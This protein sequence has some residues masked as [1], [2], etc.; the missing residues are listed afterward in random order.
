MKYKL[1]NKDIK[2][3]YLEELLRERGVTDIEQFLN[4]DSSCLQSFNDL[5]NIKKGIEFLYANLCEDKP[6]ALIVDCDIDGFTSASII[7]LYLKKVYPTLEIDYYIHSG[8]QH[9]L[10]DTWQKIVDSGRDYSLIIIPDAGSN[11]S[12]Y[13]EKLDVPILVLDHHLV[14]DEITA[15]KMVVVNNQLSPEYR[16]KDLSGAGVAY[17]FCRALDAESGNNY[18]EE[19]IDLAAVGIIGDMMSSLEPENQYIWKTG[20]KSINNTFLK[21][22]IDKQSYS[23][24]GKI[25]PISVAFYIVPL[26]NAMIRVGTIDEKERMFIAFI[27]GDRLIPCNKRGAKGTMERAAIE[28]VRECVNAKS[29]QTRLLDSAE[30][31]IEIKIFKY[32]L[33]ENKI[34]IVRLEEDDD[35][36]AELNGLVAMRLAAKHKRPTIVARLNDQGYV[37]GSIRGV[38]NGPIESFKNFLMDSGYCEYVM[39]HDNAAGVSFKNADLSK[40]HAYAN[41]ALSNVKLDEDCFDVNFVRAAADKDI[42]EIIKIVADYGDIWGQKND[43]PKFYIHDINLK[44]SDLQVIGSKKDTLKF[45]KF[46]IVYIKFHATDFIEELNQYN[47]IK[48]EVVGR[49]NVNEWMGTKTPQIMIEGYEIHDDTLGF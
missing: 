44:K 49:G 13:A 12:E 3:N 8:K 48:L 23:M 6:M 9:G 15:P 40:L 19:F 38:N 25:N 30:E 37:R 26:V 20:L 18:A 1:V 2:G 47:D 33:L 10:Q 16:N 11:D 7:Y 43:E 27:D 17:Q 22:L 31:Q 28:S 14:E 42:G 41:E 5:K 34:L 24:G 29:K 39:G 21:A 46:G 32:D 45:T 36:P 35:F 4:P